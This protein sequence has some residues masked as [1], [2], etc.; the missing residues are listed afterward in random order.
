[1]VEMRVYIEKRHKSREIE[2]PGAWFTPPIDYDELEERIG[3]T[4]QEPD[5]VIR[6]YELPFEIDE[7]MMIE[8]LNC[9]CQLVEICRNPCRTI[10][11]HCSKSMAV[12]KMCISTLPKTRILFSKRRAAARMVRG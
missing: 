11:V 2:Q 6:D 8:E 10:R 1:M 4:D 7:D 5:Y 9:L 3:V 12:W